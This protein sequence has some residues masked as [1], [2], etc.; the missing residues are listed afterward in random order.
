MVSWYW[1]VGNSSFSSLFI[2][3]FRLTE[4]ALM[5]QLVVL[6]LFGFT[7]FNSSLGKAPSHMA[8]LTLFR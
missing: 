1:N 6:A 4:S 3:L 8:Y 7:A 2:T 5:L